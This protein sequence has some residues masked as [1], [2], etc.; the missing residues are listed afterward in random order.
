MSVKV[1]T[2]EWTTRLTEAASGDPVLQEVT[3]GK[4]ILFEMHVSG[5]PGLDIYHIHFND[6]ATTF[7]PGPAENP[8]LNGSVS[9]ETMVALSRGELTGQAAAMTG[10][11][12][13]TGNMGQMMQV[14]PALDQ[15]ARIEAEIG[16]SYE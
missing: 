14:G 16:T 6:G 2:E 15:L 5:S 10:K 4:K 9:F 7:T 1:L 3:K 11:M 13:V 12:K 8:D